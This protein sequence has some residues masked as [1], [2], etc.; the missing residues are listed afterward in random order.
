MIID[1][2]RWLSVSTFKDD[3]VNERG[4]TRKSYIYAGNYPKT[5]KNVTY[6]WTSSEVIFLLKRHTGFIY[7]IF[8]TYVQIVGWLNLINGF[9]VNGKVADKHKFQWN[10]ISEIISLNFH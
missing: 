1:L 2:V 10:D 8:T 9:L 3:A 4:Y 6:V 7:S 5:T